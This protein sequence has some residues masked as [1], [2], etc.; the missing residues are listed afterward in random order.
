MR[1]DAR[2]MWEVDASKSRSPA[3]PQFRT[4]HLRSY[5]NF[6]RAKLAPLHVYFQGWDDYRSSTA[7]GRWLRVL[8]VSS[9]LIYFHLAEELR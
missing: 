2:D 9:R 8:N 5:S 7:T 6:E 4:E 1:R 3:E